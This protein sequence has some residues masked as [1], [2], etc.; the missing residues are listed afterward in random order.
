M[1][2]RHYMVILSFFAVV[3]I[4]SGCSST[5][6]TLPPEASSE[7]QMAALEG[8][9]LPLA[10]LPADMAFEEPKPEDAVILQ[11]IHFDYDQSK[12]KDTDKPILEKINTWVLN[13]PGAT[14]MIEGHC[15]ERGTLEY[16]LALGER[17]GLSIRTYLTG[18]GTNPDRLHTISYG[19]EQPLCAESVE[20][21][22]TK[23]RRGHFLVDYGESF[24][25]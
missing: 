17:R 22:W 3:I 21:C 1:K 14:L 6:K 16:N 15:D 10:E 11:D 8:M 25:E 18:L 4:L 13:H 19:E 24:N 12:I 23:N 20:D 9:D 7:D 2:M 5:P